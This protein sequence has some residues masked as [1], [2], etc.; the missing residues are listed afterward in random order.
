MP[1]SGGLSMGDRRPHSARSSDDHGLAD[2]ARCPDCGS[3][4]IDRIDHH[5]YETR[6]RIERIDDT[7]SIYGLRPYSSL[8]DRGK[9]RTGFRGVGLECADCGWYWRGACGDATQAP[10]YQR[11]LRGLLEGP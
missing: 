3:Q 5:E 4:R 7:P 6:R 1:F 11:V 9:V 8:P 10:D 2:N